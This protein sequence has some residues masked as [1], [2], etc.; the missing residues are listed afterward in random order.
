MV[1]E[2]LFHAG[3]PNMPAAAWKAGRR[4]HTP[5]TKTISASAAVT[6]MALAAWYSAEL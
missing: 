2:Q 5:S 1:N 6:R 4:S 3:R